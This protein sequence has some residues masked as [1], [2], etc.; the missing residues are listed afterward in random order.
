MLTTRH[1]AARGL[2]VHAP[3]AGAEARPESA[4]RAASDAAP[5]TPNTLTPR[6]VSAPTAASREAARRRAAADEARLSLH[7]LG[8]RG[9]AAAVDVGSGGSAAVIGQPIGT[10]GPAPAP[11]MASLAIP[12]QTGIIA[13]SQD[14]NVRPDPSTSRPALAQ[15]APG[16]P[17][18]IVDPQPAERRDGWVYVQG[19]GRDGRPLSGWVAD[20]HA[21]VFAVQRDPPPVDPRVVARMEVL[22]YIPPNGTVDDRALFNF[23]RMNGLPVTGTLDDR[24]LATMWS[25]RAQISNHV[26][27]VV[28]PAYNPSASAPSSSNNC[29]PTSVAMA[30]AAV[31][32]APIDNADPQRAIDAARAAAG[33]T[34]SDR[35]MPSDL[36][37]A[38]QAGGG[39]SYR[40]RSLA[41]LRTAIASGDPVVLFG[42]TYGGHWVMVQG[43]DPATRTWLVSDP[44]SAGGVATWSQDQL[45]AYAD[46]SSDSV[47]VRA[48]GR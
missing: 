27:Q 4:G 22:G 9:G 2:Q 31:G 46:F 23:Q 28:D 39:E 35:T 11:T 48:P 5:P 15:L 14:V 7:L 44:M 37:R 32:L 47:A 41:D 8:P 40:V 17:V 45:N 1:V 18:T 25:P 3:R 29:G 12:P 34:S 26:M 21:G 30:L 43:F 6:A 24:T 16:S 20:G 13:G 38:V 42:N 33:G 19:S 10:S 36:E